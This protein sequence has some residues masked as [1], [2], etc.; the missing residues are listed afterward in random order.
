MIEI[1]T[2]GSSKGNPGT[3]GYG[4]VVLIDDVIDYIFSEQEQYTTNNQMELKAIIHALELIKTKYK[5]N[6]C[7]I[8]SD[9]AYCVNMCNDWINKWAQN[10]WKTSKNEEIKN[11]DLIKKL[12]EL[13]KVDFPNFVIKKC[14]G[15]SGNIGN[16]LADAAASLNSI[17]FAKIKKE[18]DIIFKEEFF[19]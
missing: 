2:D 10:G 1:Y 3:G 4:V 9:S 19:I 11:I 8:Y 12:Y 13:L 14:I 15:H 6:E 17:K 16:E 5:E 7:I 18:N